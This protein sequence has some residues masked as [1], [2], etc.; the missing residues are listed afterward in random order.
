MGLWL[1]GYKGHHFQL[2]HFPSLLC[3]CKWFNIKVAVAHCPFIQVKVDQ[4]L[5]KCA[6]EPYTSGAGCYS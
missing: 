1:L 3:N 5:A 6:I 2:P 4:L